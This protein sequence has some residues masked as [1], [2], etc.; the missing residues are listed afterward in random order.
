MVEFSRR[1]KQCGEQIKYERHTTI[2]YWAQHAG[3]L[4]MLDKASHTLF[5]KRGHLSTAA[6]TAEV[7]SRNRPLRN[8]LKCSFSHSVSIPKGFCSHTHF[9]KNMTMHPGTGKHQ[10][11]AVC[12][13]YYCC[14][15]CVHHFR[16]HRWCFVRESMTLKKTK[17]N[18]KNKNIFIQPF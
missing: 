15:A 3:G 1:W 5:V 16:L 11:C 7:P 14:T 17:Q 12:T 13:H 2:V 6:S 9:V 10:A 18:T 8:H 4:I